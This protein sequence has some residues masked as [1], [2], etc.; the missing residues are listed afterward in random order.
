MSP[1]NYHILDSFPAS[2]LSRIYSH[3]HMHLERH[4]TRTIVA[5]LAYLLQTSSRGYLQHVCQSVGFGKGPSLHGAQ[6]VRSGPS[7]I[8]GLNDEFVT[9]DTADNVN[10][11]AEQVYPA[12]FPPDLARSLPAAKKS[13]DILRAAQADHSILTTSSTI[14]EIVWVWTEADVQAV[15]DQANTKVLDP[16]TGDVVRPSTSTMAT[17]S[18]R[19]YKPGLA[20]FRDFDLE[21][22]SHLTQSVTRSKFSASSTSGLR[23][24]LA[25]FPESLPAITP[26]LSH[27]T[28]L[29][30]SPLI[31]HTARLS[32]DL[33]SIFLSG[34]SNLHFQTH[35]VLLRSYLLLTS[36]S[37]R[38]RLTAALFSDVV[39]HEFDGCTAPVSPAG[40]SSQPVPDNRSSWPW[41]V[42]L[43]PSLTNRETWP[44]GGADLSFLLRTVIVDSLELAH[45]GS[46]EHKGRDGVSP[47]G[48]RVVLEEAEFRLGFAI[49]DLPLG[50]GRDRWLNPACV[51]F[52]F[53]M[54][55]LY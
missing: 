37:F 36:H 41:A 7:P 50:A 46:D 24:F 8:S 14:C 44:P 23:D 2:L 5:A 15:W 32:T 9:V 49:R 47:D 35:L 25:T 30:F 48:R 54:H 43:A 28:S 31:E 17:S 1:S 42:G 33:L 4:S 34:S 40:L 3:L 27:L 18:E 22:G 12:F 20:D 10:D 38:S 51:C 19:M 45:D 29:I 53:S 55:Y 11:Q 52:V 21:P 6:N 39:G 16:D 26:T 13:L